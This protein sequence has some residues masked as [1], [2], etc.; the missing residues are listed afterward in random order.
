MRTCSFFLIIL[1]LLG[2]QNALAQDETFPDEE[3][4]DPPWEDIRTFPYAVGDRNFTMSMGLLFP[5]FFT[6][7]ENNQHGLRIGGTASLAFNYFLTP[8]IFVGGELAG[9]FTGTRGGN[10]LYIIPFGPRIGYQFLIHRFE[11]PI[12]LMVGGVG[13]SYIE[14]GYFGLIAKPGASVFWRYNPS[15]SFGLNC[16]WWFVPQWPRNRHTVYGNFLELTLAARH[17]F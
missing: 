3:F 6:G 14:R 11:V 17:H 7:I 12:S 4:P 16:V 13:Q 9:S 8:N 10:M 5:T 1:L 2:A 15:W